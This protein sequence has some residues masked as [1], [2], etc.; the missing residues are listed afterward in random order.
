[1]QKDK[2]RY[3]FLFAALHHPFQLKKTHLTKTE[4][5][6]YFQKILHEGKQSTEEFLNLLDKQCNGCISNFVR[7]YLGREVSFLKLGKWFE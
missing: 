5:E 2:E 3:Y 1:L 7:I 4:V 6:M